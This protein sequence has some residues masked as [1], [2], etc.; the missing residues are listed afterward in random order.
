MNICTFIYLYIHIYIYIHISIYIYTRICIHLYTYLYVYLFE[1]KSPVCVEPKR[2]KELYI[3][4][5]LLV[6][7]RAPVLECGVIYTV[8]LPVECYVFHIIVILQSI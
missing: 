3:L 6:D 5:T 1:Q 8:H 2:S 4:H 7:Y